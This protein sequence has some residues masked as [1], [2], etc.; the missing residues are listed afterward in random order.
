MRIGVAAHYHRKSFVEAATY[1]TRPDI[2][3]AMRK[4]APVASARF[5]DA[6]AAEWIWQSLARGEPVDRR[7]H[8]LIPSETPA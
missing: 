6:G 3:L 5:S 8:D 2:N 4:Q 7:Y 1:L